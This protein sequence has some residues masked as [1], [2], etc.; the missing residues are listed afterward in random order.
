MRPISSAS[1][2]TS[3][4]PDSRTTRLLSRPTR[5]SFPFHRANSRPRTRRLTSPAVSTISP[6]SVRTH[7][8]IQTR[9]ARSGRCVSMFPESAMS[10]GI[11]QPSACTKARYFAALADKCRMRWHVVFSWPAGTKI[12]SP[13]TAIFASRRLR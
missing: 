4:A 13:S 9:I 3:R 10:T 7:S 6:P 1:E 2:R 8:G 5:R 12:A 11:S